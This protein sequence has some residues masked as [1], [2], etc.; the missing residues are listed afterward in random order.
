MLLN[1]SQRG[2]RNGRYRNVE[3]SF[4]ETQAARQALRTE[5]DQE[6]EEIRR[7]GE[8]L[9]CREKDTVTKA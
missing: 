5:V 3:T 6:M 9:D 1:P 7:A 4:E 2:I 8:E